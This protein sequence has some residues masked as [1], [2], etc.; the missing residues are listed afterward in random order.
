[1]R[2]FNEG[3]STVAGQMALARMP[4][5]TKS[6]ATDFIMPMTPALVVP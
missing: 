2:A 6:A 3:L 1:M 5:A 4:L